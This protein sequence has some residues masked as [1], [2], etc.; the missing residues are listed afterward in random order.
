VEESLKLKEK[1]LIETF[2]K[3]KNSLIKSI[4]KD[5]KNLDTIWNT[6]AEICKLLYFFFDAPIKQLEIQTIDLN[7]NKWRSELT[8]ATIGL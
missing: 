8:Q 3:S 5:L 6:L 4:A 7:I 1:Q 2:K